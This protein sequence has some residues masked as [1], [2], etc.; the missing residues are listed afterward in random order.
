M[1][2]CM[3]QFFCMDVYTYILSHMC[4]FTCM[5]TCCRYQCQTGDF[6]SCCD[7]E[8]L[9]RPA[10]DP[11]LGPIHSIFVPWGHGGK[12][13]GIPDDCHRKPSIFFVTENCNLW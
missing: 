5:R 9:P 6:F 7:Q 4:I 2:K 12:T 13:L 10:G 11:R 3:K 8:C 1:N